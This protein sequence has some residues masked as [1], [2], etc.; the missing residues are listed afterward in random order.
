MTI[1]FVF[2]GYPIPGIAY[3]LLDLFPL[4]FTASLVAVPAAAQL[5]LHLVPGA[6]RIP[7]RGFHTILVARPIVV[8]IAVTARVRTRPVVVAP[9]ALFRCPIDGV[10][11]VGHVSPPLLAA[12]M[13][14]Q[15]GP[16]AARKS[17]G[18]INAAPTWRFRR[19]IAWRVPYPN[20][21]NFAGRR[22]I[23]LRQPK[24]PSGRTY[25]NGFDAPVARP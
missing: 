14:S 22:A 2:A 3:T 1:G 6:A 19:Q 12:K 15:G 9:V 5:R 4:R 13:K 8:E 16:R 17:C 10:F 20:R 18:N 7:V 24:R 11:T 21:C 25:D 23:Q